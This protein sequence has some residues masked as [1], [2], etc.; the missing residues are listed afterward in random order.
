MKT[1]SV[2]VVALSVATTAWA[3]VLPD[4]RVMVAQGTSQN[5]KAQQELKGAEKTGQRDDMQ[6]MTASQQA[7]Y[8]SG[9]SSGEGEVGVADAGAKIRYGRRRAQQKTERPVL[10]G[11]RGTA[12]R[13]EERNRRPV[14][15]DEGA[16]GGSERELGQAHSIGE[17]S[18]AEV[19]VEEKA[20][21]AQW[22]RGGR[23]ARRRLRVA[24]VTVRERKILTVVKTTC[25]S[26]AYV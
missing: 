12:G 25:G 9:V 23:P 14:R 18:R 26:T 17:A 13:H 20:V 6:P 15:S 16:G 1:A 3:Q 21:R 11:A 10:H 22:Y 8:K 19:R 24:V 4:S 5:Q 7:Q 2:V